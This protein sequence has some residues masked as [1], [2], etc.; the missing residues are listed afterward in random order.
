MKKAIFLTLAVAFLPLFVAA[1]PRPADKTATVPANLPASFPARY[2]SGIFGA[3]KKE[4]GTLRFDD[5]NERVVFYRGNGQEMFSMNYTS[6]MVIYPD[7]KESMTQTGNVMSRMPLPG[8]GLFGLA[9][10][11]AKYLVINYDEPDVDAQG[12]ANFRFD[13]KDQLLTFIDALGTKAKMIRRGDA[14]YR[15]KRKSV[16]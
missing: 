5:A 16:Y 4:K 7:S 9:T 3:R 2:E 13:K 10:T 14:Y 11:S 8:A 15:A 1:Q 6:L 12:T